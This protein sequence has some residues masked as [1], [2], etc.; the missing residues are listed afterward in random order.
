MF[1]HK[2]KIQFR[3]QWHS[4]PWLSRHWGKRTKTE[5][6]EELLNSE[7]T[8]ITLTEE[9]LCS[10]TVGACIG[11]CWHPRLWMCYPWNR[12][13]GSPHTSARSSPTRHGCGQWRSEHTPLWRNPRS[14]LSHLRMMWPD[15]RLYERH[16]KMACHDQKRFS[17]HELSRFKFPR[18]LY[19]IAQWEARVTAFLK[20]QAPFKLRRRSLK[21]LTPPFLRLGLP[22]TLIR[23]EN[24]A[25][26]FEF[27]N[28][29]FSFSCGRKTFLERSF[30]KTMTSRWSRDFPARV[31]LGAYH[32][33]RKSGN[34]GLKSNGKVI[35]R[36]F[37]SQIVE[38]LQRYSSLSV[39]NGTAEIPLPFAK[40]SSFQSLISRKQLREVEVQMVSAV[41]FGWFADFGKTL[42][43]I[44]RS[45]QSVYSDKW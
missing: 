44:Q 16:V 9:R 31:F 34:F 2:R 18:A 42:T 12:K 22:S 21:T 30:S 36:K 29:G 7:R 3:L 5:C 40:L 4:N 38:Y 28:A 39:R 13:Q 14:S 41:S 35:F 26:S 8:I 25:F 10:S 11:T 19:E 43:I 45:S 24:E 20:I 15:E 32:L 27:E 23:H 17:S 33:A 1:Q 6:H 37:R